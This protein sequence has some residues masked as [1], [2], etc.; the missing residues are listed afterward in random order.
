[1]ENKGEEKKNSLRDITHKIS[2]IPTDCYNG[3]AKNIKAGI[4]LLISRN[5]IFLGE[6]CSP[7]FILATNTLK[8]H[9]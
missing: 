3:Y 1:M 8:N 7:S 6:F 4:K 2:T 9:M 5:N